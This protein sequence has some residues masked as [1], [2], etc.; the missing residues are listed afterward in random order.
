MAASVIPPGYHTV[1]PYLTV[2][3]VASLLDFLQKAF[4]ATVIERMDGPDG[5]VMHAEVRIGD[6]VVMMGDTAGRF[7]AM[8]ATLYMYV[9]DC[10]ALYKR[11]IDA[12]ATSISAPADQFYGDRHG[13]V[14][15]PS[16]NRWYIATR[17]ETVPPDELQRRA[18]EH[19]RKRQE[20]S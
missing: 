20:G 13:G 6:S 5:T 14:T 15:D 17:I 10:D 11:A 18:A 19:A 9:P 8:P 2:E 4:D 12:G 1:T 16:G 3:G 7:P